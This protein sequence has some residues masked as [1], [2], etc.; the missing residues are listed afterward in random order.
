MEVWGDGGGREQPR[1]TSALFWLTQ[2]ELPPQVLGG[3]PCPAPHRQGASPSWECTAAPRALRHPYGTQVWYLQQQPRGGSELGRMG[4]AG[5]RMLLPMLLGQSSS[6]LEQA[7]A[8]WGSGLA[9]RICYRHEYLHFPPM[10]IKPNSM[11]QFQGESEQSDTVV[12]RTEMQRKGQTL[13]CSS[14][15]DGMER[16][17]AVQLCCLSSN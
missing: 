12:L 10:D 7:L 17:A 15:S 3:S 6:Q 8:R 4:Q 11:S 14:R 13:M 2:P 9:K 5:E 1:A 16:L